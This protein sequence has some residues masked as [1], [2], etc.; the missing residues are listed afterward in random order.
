MDLPY[1]SLVN[2]EDIELDIVDE[3]LEAMAPAT[4]GQLDILIRKTEELLYREVD[5]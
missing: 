5:N 1:V 3:I 4:R 2:P